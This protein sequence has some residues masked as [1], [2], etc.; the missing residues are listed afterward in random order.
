MG[1]GYS[2]DAASRIH[3]GGKDLAAHPAPAKRRKSLGRRQR[4]LKAFAKQ[5][6]ADRSNN[7]LNPKAFTLQESLPE[8]GGFAVE[9]THGATGCRRM[10]L[11]I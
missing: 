8:G 1:A 9:I 5:R 11:D 10:N 3:I 7:D 6:C 2:D 4:P